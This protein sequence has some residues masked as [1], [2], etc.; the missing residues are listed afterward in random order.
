MKGDRRLHVGK[1]VLI[2]V[3]FPDDNS[4]QAEGE[5]TYPSGCFSMITLM[6]CV[7]VVSSVDAFPRL[8]IIAQKIAIGAA[9]FSLC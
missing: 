6:C 8:V 7:M 4:F 9:G 5:A 3:A 2:G 1:G